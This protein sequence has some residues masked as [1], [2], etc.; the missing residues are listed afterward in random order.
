MRCLAGPEIRLR[1]GSTKAQSEERVPGR[2]LLHR[3]IQLPPTVSA[4]VGIPVLLSARHS[5][6]HL[7]NV[8][9]YTPPKPAGCNVLTGWGV[10][11]HLWFFHM[12]CCLH[13]NSWC[14]QLPNMTCWFL[15]GYNNRSLW[16][17]RTRDPLPFQVA[18]ERKQWSY[19]FQAATFGA[20]KSQRVVLVHVG[21]NRHHLVLGLR[22]Q[23]NP[24]YH[25]RDAE[26][27]VHIQTAEVVINGKELTTERETMDV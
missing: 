19:L 12:S 6:R 5:Q 17:K 4:C 20:H 15:K 3:I 18:P 16:K 23:R 1:H 24:T 14:Q 9:L 8:T 21:D 2:K 13:S 22:E 26:W 7:P 25:L 11:D 10:A 27:G